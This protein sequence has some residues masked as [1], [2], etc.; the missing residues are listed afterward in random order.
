MAH[1]FVSKEV[2]GLPSPLTP[3]TIYYVRTGTGFKVYVS[4]VTGSI[5]HTQNTPTIE[6]I[7]NLRSELD[8]LANTFSGS[9]IYPS[10]I[11]LSL[12]GTVNNLA[13]AEGTNTVV[14][15]DQ[16]FTL[17]GLQNSGVNAQ[18]TFI[19]ETGTT[20]T[21]VN[22]STGSVAANR[23]STQSGDL[24]LGNGRS[25][26]MRWSTLLNRWKYISQF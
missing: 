23:F 12:T 8:S 11:S 10:E 17:T 3:N 26:T 14:L 4:D 6:E 15:V 18:V 19:N 25:V 7:T 20:V 16:G 13:L 2:A 5:A 1:L 24:V 21:F 22:E 9:V